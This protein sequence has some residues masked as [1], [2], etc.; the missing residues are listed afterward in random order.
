MCAPPWAPRTCVRAAL[1]ASADVFSEDSWVPEAAAI[2]AS[3]LDMAAKRLELINRRFLRTAVEQDGFLH[4]Y[5]RRA[6]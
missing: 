2:P 1:T 5:Q 4:E 6:Q 3:S